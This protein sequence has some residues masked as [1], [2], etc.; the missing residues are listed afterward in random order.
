MG[1]VRVAGHSSIDQSAPYDGSDAINQRVMNTAVRDVNHAVGAELKQPRLGRAQPAA[2]GEPGTEAK[3]GRLP[4]NHLHLGQTVGA[5][6]ALERAAR[7]R[8]NAVL[9]EARA[10]RARWPVRA[11]ASCVHMG[12]N[13][14]QIRREEG[15]FQ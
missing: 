10:A 3:P 12:D 11:G 9:T 1:F 8:G 13:A 5:R 14:R 6:K 2:D 4:G 7:G 15:E